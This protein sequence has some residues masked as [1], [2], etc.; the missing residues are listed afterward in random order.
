[1][2]LARYSEGWPHL[3]RELGEDLTMAGKK[4]PPFVKKSDKKAAENRNQRRAEAVRNEKSK[5]Q[6]KK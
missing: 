3:W 1:M 5:N 4:P 6:K 2:R